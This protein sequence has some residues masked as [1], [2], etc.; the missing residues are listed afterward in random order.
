MNSGE[1]DA[2]REDLGVLALR[3]LDEDERRAV[4]AHADECPECNAELDDF[5]EITALL[6]VP[7]RVA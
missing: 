2:L 6:R 4:L 1:H 3:M 5:L 7:E